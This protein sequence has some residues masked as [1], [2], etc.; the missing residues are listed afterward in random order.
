MKLIM[1]LFFLFCGSLLISSPFG[2]SEFAM[3]GHTFFSWSSFQVLI[4]VSLFFF[5]LAFHKVYTSMQAEC[6]MLKSSCIL[7]T[8]SRSPLSLLSLAIHTY[9]KSV[10]INQQS[11]PM[12]QRS[13][14]YYLTA[15][16]RQLSSWTNL[17]SIQR[18]KKIH[19]PGVSIVLLKT[20]VPPT[21]QRLA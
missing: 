16:K 18:L 20:H 17:C 12:L 2:F 14:F 5:F 13:Y 15:S 6:F 4:G 7:Q 9:V 19:Y 10:N 8:P 3:Q 1:S 21:V 11:T